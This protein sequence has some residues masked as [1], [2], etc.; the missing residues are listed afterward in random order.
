M[1]S[2]LFRNGFRSVTLGDCLQDPKENWYRVPSGDT[3][4]PTTS[5]TRTAT[6]TSPASSST[7]IPPGLKGTTD[8]R[9]G[10][11]FGETCA[12]EKT[13]RCCSRYSWCKS[14]WPPDCPNLLT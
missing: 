13:A 2:S 6:S 4:F 8:G 11:A 12:T 5:V 14:N 1:L 9:C 7:S 10:P 3:S